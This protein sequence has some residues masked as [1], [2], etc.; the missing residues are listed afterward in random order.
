MPL[1]IYALILIKEY[2]ILEKPPVQLDM[3]TGLRGHYTPF[4][5]NYAYLATPIF[6]ALGPLDQRF[7]WQITKVVCHPGVSW[8][9]GGNGG[10]IRLIPPILQRCHETK[11]LD[12]QV[13]GNGGNGWQRKCNSI[14]CPVGHGH[15]EASQSSKPALDGR[16]I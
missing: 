1:G 2:A 16:I 4:Y 13:A 12:H 7:L 11:S 15:R 14:K 6:V 9:H 10:I 3:V 5:S 8:H